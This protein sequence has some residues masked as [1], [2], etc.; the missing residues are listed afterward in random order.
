MED[1]IYLVVSL[2]GD[3]ACLRRISDPDDTGEPTLVAR[4]L[5]PDGIG[6][7]MRLKRVLFDYE[8]VE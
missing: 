4:A 3:Y 6:E 8:I 2:D 1:M 5:L 7:G